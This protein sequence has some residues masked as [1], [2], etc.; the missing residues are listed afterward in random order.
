[1]NDKNERSLLYSGDI[2]LL[3]LY[4][5]GDYSGTVSAYTYPDEFEACLGSIEPVIGI[6]LYQQSKSTFGVSYR[7][8]KGNDTDGPEYGYL[9]HLIYGCE[10][11]EKSISRATVNDS[12]EAVEFSWDFDCMPQIPEDT[13]YAPFSELVI[14]STK[15]NSEFMDQLED[16][17]YGT[18]DT[19]ARMPTLEELIELFYVE[20]PPPADW[21]GYPHDRVY[22]SDEIYPRSIYEYIAGISENEFLGTDNEEA[23]AMVLRN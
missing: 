9:L 18:E 3:S 14:D 12:S 7:S 2:K 17:L 10:I 11:S 4:A 13:A 15:F 8:Q 23:I 6:R 1:M 19:P 22:P 16:I 5:Y 21:E 20:E